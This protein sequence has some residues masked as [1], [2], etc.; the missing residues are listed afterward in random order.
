[1]KK[2]LFTTTALFG[3]ALAAQPALAFDQSDWTW[4]KTVEETVNVDVTIDTDLT[5]EGHVEIQK[6][7]LMNGDTRAEIDFSGNYLSDDSTAL[8]LDPEA[9]DLLDQAA[10]FS[11]S[12]T[13]EGDYVFNNE[14]VGNGGLVVS[15]VEITDEEFENFEG[16]IA[17]DADTAVIRRQPD[18]SFEFEMTLEG[19]AGL[20]G[21]SLDDL[22]EVTEVTVDAAEEMGTLAG[23]A[24]A[25]ANFQ[26]LETE[27]ATFLD[28]E[29]IHNSAEAGVEAFANAG[30]AEDPVEAGVD[31]AATGISNYMAYES[32]AGILIG[33]IR[34][35]A[36]TDV[37][38]AA[39]ATQDL[40]G[41]NNLSGYSV[42]ADIAGL[43]SRLNATG[44]GNYASL[45]L[46]PSVDLAD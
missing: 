44:I 6:S 37:L 2:S 12:F 32:A 14:G 21:L 42:D 19:T 35:E 30:S 22:V 15:N 40:S 28:E 20:T 46:G 29:Q 9:V 39:S 23:N 27:T 18:G 24:T 25:I 11:G 45:A 38:A 36:N 33:D 3:L 4:I 10:A 16:T 26:E 7:Q 1:M 5:P 31:L 8:V 43:T 34:Q 13:L 17:M 41:F